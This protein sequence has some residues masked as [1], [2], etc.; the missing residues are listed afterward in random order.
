MCLNSH[1]LL[2]LSNILMK[3]PINGISYEVIKNNNTVHKNLYF[4]KVF[5]KNNFLLFVF[6]LFKKKKTISE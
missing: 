3:F 2:I 6:F 1:L 5:V 4:Q